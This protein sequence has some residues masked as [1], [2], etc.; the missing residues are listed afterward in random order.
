MRLL[1][2]FAFVVVWLAGIAIAQGALST[3]AA[4]LLPPW[5]VY[6]TVSRALLVAG[7]L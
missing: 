6:L 3:L 7:W 2:E 5:A 4:V 1:L